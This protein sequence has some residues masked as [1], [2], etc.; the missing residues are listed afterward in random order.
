MGNFE[1]SNWEEEE[2]KNLEYLNNEN[3]DTPLKQDE[4]DEDPDGVIEES[5]DDKDNF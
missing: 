2:I 3:S 4:E 1:S 5:Y